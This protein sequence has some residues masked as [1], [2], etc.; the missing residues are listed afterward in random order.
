MTYLALK[1]TPTNLKAWVNHLR[2]DHPTE[3]SIEAP[4]AQTAINEC[5]GT[6]LDV[7]FT[8]TEP[9]FW[10][11][12][13]FTGKKSV[14]LD[15][16]AP[17]RSHPFDETIMADVTEITFT[18]RFDLIT[19]ISTLEH[20]GCDVTRY[21]RG[22]LRRADPGGLQRAVVEKLRN[23]SDKLLVSVPFGMFEDHGWFLQYDREMVER[24]NPTDVTY[25]DASGREDHPDRLAKCL[26]RT[27]ELRASAVALL[28]VL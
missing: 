15:I 9:D 28:E 26:Y 18:E 23:A 14:G 12:V 2:K 21:Q 1:D 8:W 27:D 7:G 11:G 16:A 19:C 10:E 4:W 13:H 6:W 20:I 3:R 25:C 22:E 17:F 24:L 5:K